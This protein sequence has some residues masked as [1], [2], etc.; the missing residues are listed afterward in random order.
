M[1]SISNTITNSIKALSDR[2]ESSNKTKRPVSSLT[3][4][5]NMPPHM[6]INNTQNLL[7][8]KTDAKKITKKRP[9]TAFISK[10][11]KSKEK[12]D[13]KE[14]KKK[15]EKR[16]IRNRRSKEKKK[17]DEEN[18]S[19]QNNSSNINLSS[20]TD[21]SNK[22]TSRSRRKKLTQIKEEKNNENKQKSSPKKIVET[23]KKTQSIKNTTT[24][25]NLQT[26]TKNIHPQKK[27]SKNLNEFDADQFFTLLSTEGKFPHIQNKNQFLYDK[28]NITETVMSIIDIVEFF[29]ENIK[30]EDKKK[31]DQLIHLNMYK[32]TMDKFIHNKTIIKRPKKTKILSEEQIG[33]KTFDLYNNKINIEEDSKNFS[34]EEFSEFKNYFYHFGN[35]YN[36]NIHNIFI[37]KHKLG[38]IKIEINDVM[39]S[40]VEL[41]FDKARRNGKSVTDYEDEEDKNL[42]VPTNQEKELLEVPSDTCNNIYNNNN[43]YNFKDYLFTNLISEIIKYK[44]KNKENKEEE[45]NKN[46]DNENK[47]NKENEPQNEINK[48]QN[49]I[50]I[51]KS[52]PIRVS[53]LGPK[54]IGKRTLSNLLI[55]QYPNIKIYNPYQI[56]NE[57]RTVKAKI[58]EPPPQNLT[59]NQM[60]N[61]QKEKNL[62]SEQYKELFSF[63]GENDITLPDNLISDE[64]LVDLIIK[65]IKEDFSQKSVEN[66]KED[67]E[68]KRNEISRL[69]SEL[70]RVKEEQAKKGRVNERELDVFRKQ[71]NAIN[72]EAMRGFILINFPV[73]K[74]QVLLMEKKMMGII[75]PCEMPKPEIDTLNEKL[76]AILDKD[77]KDMKKIKKDLTLQSIFYMK[78]G[79]NCDIKNYI[80]NR[81]INYKK[82][83]FTGIIYNM[84]TN[85]I[86][87]RNIVKRLEEINKT[88]IE[89]NIDNEMLFY[90]NFIYD[91]DDFYKNYNITTHNL[92][93]TSNDIIINN[94]TNIYGFFEEQIKECLNR[95]ENKFLCKNNVI[96]NSNIGTLENNNI[97]NIPNIPNIVNNNDDGLANIKEQDLLEDLS[98][99]K[100]D[101]N[102]ISKQQNDSFMNNNNNN[103]NDISNINNVNNNVVSA[104]QIP[105]NIIQISNEEINK[106]FYDWNN[107][108]NYYNYYHYRL[109]YRQK[110]REKEVGKFKEKL[111]ILQNDFID[112]ISALSNKKIIIEQFIN[113]YKTFCKRYQKLLIADTVKN[114]YNKDL[115]ELNDSLWDIVKIKQVRAL[116]QIKTVQNSNKILNEIDITYYTMERLLILETYKLIIIVNLLLRYFYNN[117]Y[118]NT[119]VTVH[120]FN[121][122]TS[123]SEEILKNCS[124]EENAS[125]NDSNKEYSYPKANRLYK[126]CFRVLIKLNIFIDDKLVQAY[127]SQ[128]KTKGGQNPSSGLV[129]KKKNK[130]GGLSK[131]SSSN[132]IYQITSL[133]GSKNDL[134]EQIKNCISKEIG[135]YKNN[136]YCIYKNSLENLSQVYIASKEML[137]LMEKWVIDSS[138]YQY[139]AIKGVINYLKENNI[140]EN[141]NKDNNNL[142]C[143]DGQKEKYDFSND[144]D[145]IFGLRLDNFKE[146]YKKLTYD[147]MEE[148]TI[149][150]SK[151]NDYKNIKLKYPNFLTE[152]LNIVPKLKKNEI[153]KG[154]IAKEK[155]EEI[156]FEYFFINNIDKFPYQFQLM[157][158]RNFA[159]YLSHFAKKFSGNRELIYTNDIITIII[160]CCFNLETVKS[161]NSDIKNILLKLQNKNMVN[162][163]QFI[164]LFKEIKKFKSSIEKIFEGFNFND[165]WNNFCDCLFDINKNDNELI[166]M[167]NFVKIIC[168]DKYENKN[169]KNYFDLFIKN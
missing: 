30:R 140:L 121:L 56:I 86:K 2:T 98:S 127:E 66:I 82:D 102:N 125:Y 38:D 115:E 43:N 95:Y 6:N 63:V 45:I 114:N 151:S 103:L 67:I 12:K 27:I 36:I 71:I 49:I 31:I 88:L 23:T 79:E 155:F 94:T 138:G 61:L 7:P 55:N 60:D 133:L 54:F 85:P 162:K 92:E 14:K 53:I 64:L 129:K 157:N 117:N 108:L 17:T 130:K 152:I 99:C 107:F 144:D 100:F 165:I 142:V 139:T 9:V 58:K 10:H 158:F 109:F 59:R 101:N 111:E 24:N 167:E 37:K 15:K 90:Q 19:S 141:Y 5:K 146:K 83:P 148:K 41:L 84:A 26:A 134:R 145:K 116:E 47:E 87:D 164:Q 52:I 81:T 149:K 159:I 1:S 3:T 72:V 154:L 160:F 110:I 135:K 74:S 78:N 166:N 34:F 33:N 80:L 143:K 70:D 156:F 29:A 106:I 123:I 122:E 42:Y 153:Q 8:T 48:S 105:I 89:N 75:Q 21:S 76:L 119:N 128:K 96:G 163:E 161:E 137:A 91:S 20:K 69:N 132:S 168:L 120:Q 13:K 113:K 68:K 18:I 25:S 35:K 169:I 32:E 118:L 4:G 65:K 28:M 50:D 136:V 124:N 39:G 57:L 77:Y 147:F 126:N 16:H 104:K 150:F 11:S 131:Q 46:T 51:I 73:K 97:P 112:F 22:K 62:L 40:E 44:V 93:I